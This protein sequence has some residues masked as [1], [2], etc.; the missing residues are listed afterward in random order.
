MPCLCWRWLYL[1][2]SCG[3]VIPGTADRGK[4][5]GAPPF[6]PFKQAVKQ[7]AS[8]G[9]QA[10]VKS[11]PPPTHDALKTSR[12]QSERSNQRGGG[13]EGGGRGGEGGRGGGRGGGREG[14][15][16]GRRGGGGGGGGG[17]AHRDKWHLQ[18]QQQHSQHTAS[19]KMELGESTSQ[20]QMDTALRQH[21][22]PG[23]TG[24][25]GEGATGPPPKPPAESRHAHVSSLS[26]LATENS[27]R[28]AASRPDRGRGARGR[29]AGLEDGEERG[30]RGGRRG[31]RG[32]RGDDRG[33]GSSSK[34]EYQLAD[35]FSQA[36]HLGAGEKDD[37]TAAELLF[38]DGVGC[39]DGGMLLPEPTADSSR[40]ERPRRER[41]RGCRDERGKGGRR[42]R[43][44]RGGYNQRESEG[45]LAK[46]GP[47]VV[48]SG[49]E[50]LWPTLQGSH[51]PLSRDSDGGAS[52]WVEKQAGVDGGGGAKGSGPV[53]SRDRDGSRRGE[54]PTEVQYVWE[55]EL[56]YYDDEV[57]E[58]WPTLQGGNLAF[59]DKECSGGGV[60]QKG[61]ELWKG[62]PPVAERSAREQ[63]MV[64]GKKGDKHGRQ[65][66]QERGG[67]REEPEAWE[68]Q[69]YFEDR[70]VSEAWPT[71]QGNPLQASKDKGLGKSGRQDAAENW[72]WVSSTG[73]PSSAKKILFWGIHINYCFKRKYICGFIRKICVQALL[74]YY[75]I[76]TTPRHALKTR[77]H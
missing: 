4:G 68:G 14:E 19:P 32:D 67:M 77:N 62:K 9:P 15:R 51:A 56:M 70:S 57:S 40:E 41:G 23:I 22:P 50:E 7:A 76:C 71:L 11:A 49:E 42:G 53:A 3:Q 72:D 73:V 29:H 66:A 25:G 74:S 48:Y 59:G 31:R 46:G 37:L 35:W 63:D 65:S 47:E 21:P 38:E 64:K 30:G 69:R 20:R 6:V 60:A 33:G 10:S 34:G 28:L 8:S 39:Y 55:D 18:Q 26:A 44:G 16:G 58:A 17:E 27:L 2:H 54:E 61:G 1:V 13:R 52:G 43:R 75:S 24:G 45:D 36:L 12:S 5:T